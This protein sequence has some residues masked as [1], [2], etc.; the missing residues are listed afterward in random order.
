MLSRQ[1]LSQAVVDVYINYTRINTGLTGEDGVVLLHIPYQPRLP[2]VVVA[3][4]DGYMC[5]LLPCKT[6]TTP[7]KYV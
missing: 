4:K 6:R 7:S 3:S 2:V 5:T 1:Y